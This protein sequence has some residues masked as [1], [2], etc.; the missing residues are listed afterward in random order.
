MVPVVGVA[1]K[2]SLSLHDAVGAD[3]YHKS[4]LD[5]MVYVTRGY[6]D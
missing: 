4:V 2:P 1:S 3:V 6:V 5:V